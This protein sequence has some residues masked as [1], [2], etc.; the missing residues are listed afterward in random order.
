MSNLYAAQ[1]LDDSFDE[2]C[3]LFQ[4]WDKDIPDVVEQLTRGVE[5][6][7]S[8]IHYEFYDDN[9]AAEFIEAEFDR[10]LVNC[11]HSCAIPAMR[12]DLFRYCF[13]AKR[14]GIYIDADYRAVGSV[15][16]II[17]SEW[18]G[19][20][21][22]RE[23]GLANGLMY[24]QS[25]ENPLALKIL[26]LAIHNIT[27][28]VSNNVW[29]VTGPQVLQSLYADENSRD[30]FTGIHIMDEEEFANYFKPAVNLQYKEDDSHWLVARQKGL[31]IFRD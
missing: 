25:A 17:S 31:S 29:Q 6:T 20:L 24:F 7:N 16:P 4:F 18:G 9:S 30:L 22:M 13:L 28:R 3:C 2:T 11:Y 19:C 10:E 5:E 8:A 14:G 1:V 21:Y 15:E 23:R 27:N 26:K 12:A